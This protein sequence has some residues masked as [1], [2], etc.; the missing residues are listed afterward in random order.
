MKNNHKN[1]IVI[2]SH[3]TRLRRLQIKKGGFKTYVAHRHFY[4]VKVRIFEISEEHRVER[5]PI[6]N[7]FPLSGLA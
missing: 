3:K 5:G 1:T 7:P 2:M 6:Y 4:Y